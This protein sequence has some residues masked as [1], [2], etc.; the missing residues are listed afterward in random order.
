MIHNLTVRNQDLSGEVM[1]VTWSLCSSSRHMR[2]RDRSPL[3]ACDQSG[4]LAGRTR[5][6]AGLLYGVEPGQARNRAEDNRSAAITWGR[7]GIR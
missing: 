7:W 3:A 4:A 1:S 5:L 2:L 6:Q